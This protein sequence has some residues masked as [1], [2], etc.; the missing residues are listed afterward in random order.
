[1]SS[2]IFFEFHVFIC[3]N[4]QDFRSMFQLFGNQS[5]THYNVADQYQELESVSNDCVIKLLS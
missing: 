2:A 1:M 3:T 5:T 4:V